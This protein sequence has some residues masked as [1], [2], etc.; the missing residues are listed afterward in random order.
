[1]LC[2]ALNACW[3]GRFAKVA[4]MEMKR[5]LSHH[6]LAIATLAHLSQ[7]LDF[8]FGEKSTMAEAAP[9][10]A[11]GNNANAANHHYQSPP[12]RRALKLSILVILLCVIIFLSSFNASMRHL[13]AAQ[14]KE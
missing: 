14:K 11:A 7:I 9:A 8:G 1:M 5:Y 3:Q 6:L 2:F 13:I 4:A 10:A 12:Q